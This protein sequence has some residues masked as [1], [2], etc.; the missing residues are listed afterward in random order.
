MCIN[1]CKPSQTGMLMYIFS[2]FVD[3]VMHKDKPLYSKSELTCNS[4]LHQK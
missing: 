4:Q 2:H 1:M 3:T